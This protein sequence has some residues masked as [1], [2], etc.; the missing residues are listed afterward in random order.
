MALQ[1]SHAPSQPDQLLPGFFVHNAG[2]AAKWRVTL[3]RGWP[4]G[5]Y[6]T[7]QARAARPTTVVHT[8]I[9]AGSQPFP[10]ASIDAPPAAGWV[11]WKLVSL[12]QGI[13][14]CPQRG[15]KLVVIHT[16]LQDDSHLVL[17]V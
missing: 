2:T 12:A 13:D 8:Y 17:E 10:P 1:L 4:Q 11:V 7:Q 15:N 5:S 9:P 3:V 16:F 6:T 14:F